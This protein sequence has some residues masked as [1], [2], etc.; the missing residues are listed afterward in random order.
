VFLG[1]KTVSPQQGFAKYGS[2]RDLSFMPAPYAPPRWANGCQ[3]LSL[4]R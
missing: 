2:K 3:P 1:H 4:I